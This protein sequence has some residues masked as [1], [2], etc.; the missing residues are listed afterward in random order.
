MT[1]K[2]GNLFGR[3]SFLASTSA[4]G[5][6]SLLGLPRTATAEPQPETKRIRLVKVPAVCLAPEYLA[7]E[8]L[9]SEGFSE[10]EYAEI[11][12][13]T[14]PDMLLANRADITAWTPPASDARLGCRETDGRARRYPWRL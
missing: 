13:T 3:R 11:H 5:A 7:E 12:Q 10:I 4:L 14:A 2:T 1:T 9:R 6:A 8:L